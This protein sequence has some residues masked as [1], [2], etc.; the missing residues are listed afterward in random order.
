MKLRLVWQQQE[1]DHDCRRVRD[2]SKLYG[3]GVHWPAAGFV[4]KQLS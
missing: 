2:D 1:V 4:D 3:A